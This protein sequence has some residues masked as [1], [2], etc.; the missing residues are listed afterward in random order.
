M[1]ENNKY[2]I[3]FEFKNG[4]SYTLSYSYDSK[5]Q[6]IKY[7]DGL[8]SS[9]L[10]EKLGKQVL[11]LES[12]LIHEMIRENSNNVT[13]DSVSLYKEQIKNNL[14]KIDLGEDFLIDIM[15]DIFSLKNLCKN[16]L[17]VVYPDNSYVELDNKRVKVSGRYQDVD[18]QNKSEQ[19]VDQVKKIHEQNGNKKITF[20]EKMIFAANW[21]DDEH[22]KNEISPSW[23]FTY[24][25]KKGYGNYGIYYEDLKSIE[26]FKETQG[27]D[28][29]KSEN[30]EKISLG[31]KIARIIF[32]ILLIA[33][34]IF[35]PTYL[36]IVG[37]LFSNVAIPII[38][39]SAEAILITLIIIF[40][41]SI[42]NIDN[43]NNLLQKQIGLGEGEFSTSEQ[44]KL[45]DKGKNEKEPKNNPEPNQLIKNNGQNL[46]EHI[47]NDK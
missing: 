23:I 26:Y 9:E 34:A 39:F 47:Q 14:E 44:E 41:L 5:A 37:L 16:N 33:F 30:N 17:E 1:K 7:G 36:G 8:V 6:A 29:Q 43:E 45:M 27:H 42:R 3:K 32:L 18:C 40:I 25:Y 12:A 11:D 19:I 4:E 2:Q 38:V 22:P 24:I 31:G 15:P 28:S 21:D 20:V 46:G 10:K 13:D 35:L